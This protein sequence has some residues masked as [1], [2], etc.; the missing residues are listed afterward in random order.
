M[1]HFFCCTGRKSV[2]VHAR[3][4]LDFN[5]GFKMKV[6]TPD[7]IRA[8]NDAEE[9]ESPQPVTCH[10]RFTARVTGC[11]CSQM[12]WFTFLHL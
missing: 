7:E 8:E 6:M 9:T 2:S 10:G 11:I 3:D 4:F 1:L 12:I 5:S